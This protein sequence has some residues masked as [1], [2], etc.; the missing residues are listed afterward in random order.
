MSID[1]SPHDSRND[2]HATLVDEGPA[3]TSSSEDAVIP[4]LPEED[5]DA[6]TTQQYLKPLEAHPTQVHPGALAR[7]MIPADRFPRG[8]DTLVLPPAE[9]IAKPRVPAPLQELPV[10]RKKSGISKGILLLV[11]LGVLFLVGYLGG[12]ILGGD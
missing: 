6:T 12:K 3:P 9:E 1:D 4:A 7:G 5:G 10:P 8:G 11:G 2:P